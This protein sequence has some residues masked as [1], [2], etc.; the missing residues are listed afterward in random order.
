MTAPPRV[1]AAAEIKQRLTMAAVA[2]MYGF[3]PSREGFIRCPF[4]DNGNERTASLKIYPEAYPG[5]HGFYCHACTAGGS[6]I[7]FAM[8]LFSVKPYEAMQKLNDDFRLGL[9]LPSLSD[10]E[11]AR[12]RHRQA[13]QQERR[14]I[15][16]QAQPKAPPDYGVFEREH[17][18]PGG[19]VKKTIYRRRDG[20]K[21]AVWYH[22]EGRWI[23]GRGDIPH[24]LYQRGEPKRRAYVAEGEKDADNLFS[25]FGGYC[26]SGENGAGKGKWLPEY[27]RLLQFVGVQC[28]AIFADNDDIGRAYA[29]ETAA[30]LS[31]ICRVKLIDLRQIWP[32]MPEKADVSDYIAANPATARENIGR[33]VRETEEIRMPPIQ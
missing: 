3:E 22:W 6:V 15:Q 24:I 21:Y 12:L 20:T 32:D 33:L 11:T 28:A 29:Q 8:K 18:Y 13:V 23:K 10:S 27:T 25:L 30:A 4:H 14:R 17:I 26:V 16:R 5:R 9:P 1:N 31:A 2:E 7:D 19:Q